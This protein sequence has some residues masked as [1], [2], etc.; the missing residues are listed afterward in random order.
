MTDPA[1]ILKQ[2][3]RAVPAV[4]YALGVAGIVAVI[5]IV[6]LFGLSFGVAAL[7]AVVMLVLMAALVIFA[8]LSA[9]G[10]ADFRLPALVFAWFSLL[11]LIGSSLLLFTSTF[12]GKPLNLIASNAPAFSSGA[13]EGE[14]V[15]SKAAMPAL[16]G[17]EQESPATSSAATAT[18]TSDP[19]L[20]QWAQKHSNAQ[21]IFDRVKGKWNAWARNGQSCTGSVAERSFSSTSIEI[22]FQELEL[23]NDHLRAFIT[24]TVNC[25]TVRLGP[26][27]DMVDFQ[28]KGRGLIG[29]TSI[30]W[31]NSKLDP[32]PCSDSKLHSI[33][34]DVDGAAS[35]L[36]VG[37]WEF[38]RPKK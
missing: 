4:K 5:A 32:S 2:A 7:G 12:F 28:V 30:S 3:V 8:K 38:T 1:L 16:A 14:Q 26:H 33:T 22:D 35:L 6:K 31:C 18:T 27:W 17:A 10:S 11:L 15:K 9:L 34:V 29:E 37:A 21:A 19:V 25:G 24:S 36:K 13:V 23:A 20:A